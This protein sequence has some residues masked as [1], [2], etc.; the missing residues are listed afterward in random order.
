MT[1]E[2]TL[3]RKPSAKLILQNRETVPGKALVIAETNFV[4]RGSLTP[5]AAMAAVSVRQ[6]GAVPKERKILAFRRRR[7]G[8][9]PRGQKPGHYPKAFPALPPVPRLGRRCFLQYQKIFLS[10]RNSPLLPS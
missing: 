8:R 3:S 10:I 1:S 6:R 5:A 4:P 9:D 2:K 7:A